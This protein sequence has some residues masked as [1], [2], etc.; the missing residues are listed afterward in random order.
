[1]SVPTGGAPGDSASGGPP[2]PPAEAVAPGAITTATTTPAT[3]AP[4]AIPADA[5]AGAASVR[6]AGAVDPADEEPGSGRDPRFPDPDSPALPS[7]VQVAR[8]FGVPIYVQPG[9]LIVAAALLTYVVEPNAAVQVARPGSYALAFSFAVLLYGSVLV[10]ELAHSVVAQSYGLRVRRISLHLL[11]G[12]SEIEEEA[13]TPGREFAI[14]FAGPALSF[15]VFGVA[16]LATLALPGDSVAWWLARA[17]A[18]ANLVVGIFNLLPGLPL[19]G[20]RVMQA[21]VW[22]VTG[23]RDTG[24]VTAAWGGRVLAVLLL[25]VAP[26]A[27]LMGLRVQ[28]ITVVW[29]AV[30]A[31]FL[32]AGATGTLKVAKF[33]RRLPQL[34]ARVLGRRAIAVP[35][36]TPVADALRR[37]ILT[38]APGILVLD[39]AH[40]VTGLVSADAVRA[41]PEERRAVVPISDLARRVHPGLVLSADSVGEDLLRALQ[42]HPA[43]EYVLVESDG[44]VYGVLL[45]ADVERATAGW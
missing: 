17:L 12:V 27:L 31:A 10:H 39:P 9:W 20:G 30:I 15:A 5:H 43:M 16:M 26:V 14:A 35:P 22:R 11:G 18:S 29:T 41:M 21:G 38:R 34:Q 42:A 36:E 8:L 40:A 33:R 44:S 4:P 32:W 28:L 24:V 6:D 7:G 25:L 19:D 13:P 23:S 37:A 2:A 1:M 45:A 3:P